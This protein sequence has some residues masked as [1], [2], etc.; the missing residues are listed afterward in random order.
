MAHRAVNGHDIEKSFRLRNSPFLRC[1]PQT[2]PMKTAQQWVF[3]GNQT[4]N[5]TPGGGQLDPLVS[6]P[7]PLCRMVFIGRGVPVTPGLYPALFSTACFCG[8]SGVAL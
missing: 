5:L 2:E 7:N 3:E 8:D 6:V 1:Y 4:P